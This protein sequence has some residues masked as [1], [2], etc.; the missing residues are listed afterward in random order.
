MEEIEELENEIIKLKT[1]LDEKRIRLREL[2]QNMQNDDANKLTN[3][4]IARYSRQ[5]IIPQ[6]GVNGQLKLKSTSI[7]IVGAGGL[8]CP[9]LQYL[10][11]S[12]IKNIGIVDYDVVEITNLHRQILH[13]ENSLGLPKTISAKKQLLKMNSNIDIKTYNCGI[14]SETALEIID[15]YD[16]ILD[17]TD[18]VAT[19]Y[20]LNDACCLAKKPLVSGSALKLEG[21]LTVYNYKSGPCYRCIFPIPP[22]PEAVTNCGDAGILGPVTGV[23]GSLQ[24]LEA[25]KIALGMDDILSGRMLIFDGTTTTFRNI[26]LR[27]KRKDCDLCSEKPIITH[28]ID[29]E[30]F[31]GMR[32][33]DKNYSLKVLERNDRITVLDYKMILD[34]NKPNLLIDVRNPI[35]YE[36]CHL[37]NSINIPLK[38]I[39]EDENIREKIQNNNENV[40]VFLLCRRG[41][42]SQ[43]A[44]QHLKEKVKD[45]EFKDIIGGL[46]AW[47]YQIDETFPIY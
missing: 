42:D 12:G 38:K 31:C 9:A 30:Q 24:A 3:D 14:F 11:S 25:I 15:M 7:L 13:T 5:I 27:N 29:Y 36:M 44:V 4:D 16:I 34:E 6:I 21:Q 26:R 47:H 8:G 41:N 46:Y 39:L 22:P 17:C 10:V 33:T 1:L 37:N 28:L 45:I 40:P 32:A 23:I 19:R 2:K 35:E 43:L 18:N 20:L